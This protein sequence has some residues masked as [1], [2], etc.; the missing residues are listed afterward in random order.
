MQIDLLLSSVNKLLTLEVLS[1]FRLDRVT[2]RFFTPLHWDNECKLCTHLSNQ[3][4]HSRHYLCVKHSV[5]TSVIVF[6]SWKDK[7]IVNLFF[8]KSIP[9]PDTHTHTHTHTQLLWIAG[10]QETSSVQN[11]VAEVKLLH[12]WLLLGDELFKPHPLS[13]T[14]LLTNHE[15]DQ[16]P[17]N[18]IETVTQLL[19]QFPRFS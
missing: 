10:A 4:S 9:A 12:K 3:E 8:Y 6:N 11:Y 5:S 18:Q 19:R 7:L 14:N 2:K 1:I 16:L 15:T 13:Q 17:H